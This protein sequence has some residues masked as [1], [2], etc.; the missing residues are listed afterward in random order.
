M[1]EWGNAPRWQVC[2]AWE[3][4]AAWAQWQAWALWLFWLHPEQR[5][6]LLWHLL[7]QLHLC[8]QSA[9]RGWLFWWSS[10]LPLMLICQGC[11]CNCK[12]WWMRLDQQCKPYGALMVWFMDKCQSPGAN[13]RSWGLREVTEL[14]KQG[15]VG[16]TEWIWDMQ[17]CKTIWGW[18]LGQFNM[19]G[20]KC[21]TGMRQSKVKKARRDKVGWKYDLRGV[22]EG[23][24]T[25]AF[26]KV[27]TL[28][29][30]SLL[31]EEITGD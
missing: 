29:K 17:W 9:H 6:H 12:R 28:R 8:C 31:C 7:M 23:N 3:L 14:G 18:K 5:W 26:H 11:S 27:Q 21:D 13:M 24:Q 30:T 25:K 10:N 22:Y 19:R 16:E 1:L 2:M 20:T 15:D 4:Y